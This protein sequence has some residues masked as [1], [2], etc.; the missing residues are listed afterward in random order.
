MA[1]QHH[2]Y[3]G[4]LLILFALLILL[5]AIL[6]TIAQSKIMTIE[7]YKTGNS[8]LNSAKNNVLTAYILGYVAA[9]M[10]VIL[11]ILYFGHVAWGIKNEIPHLL[12]FIILFGLIITSGVFSFIALSNISGSNAQD[13]QGSEGWIWAALISALVA[14]I[15]LII[16]GAW[17]AQHVSSQKSAADTTVESQQMTTIRAPSEYNYEPMPNVSVGPTRPVPVASPSRTVYAT[18]GPGYTTQG[19][20]NVM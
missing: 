9:G 17:R 15:V 8:K 19:T 6:L 2:K 13:K 11:A 16:S 3:T 10:A 14:I 5:S 18:S 1:E 20:V 12:V 7:E 4:A